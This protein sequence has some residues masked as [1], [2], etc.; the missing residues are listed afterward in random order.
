MEKLSRVCSTWRATQDR[1]EGFMKLSLHLLSSPG[2]WDRISWD[3]LEHT[4]LRKGIPKYTLLM[5]QILFLQI[6]P[7]LGLHNP[8]NCFTSPYF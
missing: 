7:F 6:L 4:I 5:P 1:L 3:L 2:Q 8:D